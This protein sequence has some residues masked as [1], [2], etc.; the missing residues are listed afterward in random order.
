MNR[1]YVYELKEDLILVGLPYVI[2]T[3][4]FFWSSKLVLLLSLTA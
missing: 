1:A 4:L 2:R 3:E